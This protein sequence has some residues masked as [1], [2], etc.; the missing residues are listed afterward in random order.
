MVF[1]VGGTERK[2]PE[3]VY[4][5]CMIKEEG[6]AIRAALA[7]ESVPDTYFYLKERMRGDAL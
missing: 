6:G 5:V 7:M 4:F 2:K 3:A 1:R